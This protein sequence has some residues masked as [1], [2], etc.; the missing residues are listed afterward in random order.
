MAGYSIGIDLGTTY[1]CVGVFRNG[2]VEIIANSQGDRTTPSCVAFTDTDRLIG[3]AAMS[4]IAANPANT[5]YE[6]KRLIGRKWS[7]AKAQED[8]RNFGFECVAVA[9]DIQIKVEHCGEKK[10]FYPEQ[11]SA[12]VLEQLKNDAEAYL[13][14]K[15]TDAVITVPAYFNDAQRRKTEDAARIAGLNP[16]RIVNEPTAAALAYG[17]ETKTDGAGEK[18]VLVFDMGGGTHDVSLLEIDSGMVQTIATAGDTHLG[19]A[20]FDSRLVAHL[21]AEFKRRT[22]KDIGD[23]KRATA[24]LRAAAERAKRT[25]SS[26]THASIEIDALH[27][28]LDLYTSVSRARFEELCSDLFQKAMTP[29]DRVLLDARIDKHK[30]TDIILVG[31]STRVPKI[32]KLLQ[33]YFGGKELCKSVNPDECVAYGAAV[34]AAI[35]G[36]APS[37]KV[38]VTDMVLVDVCPL[39]LGIETLGGI[40]TALIKRNST[41]PTFA[42]QTFTT[43]EDGQPGVFIQVFEGE[44]ALTKDCNKLGEF[45]LEGIPPAQAGVPKIEVRF[46]LDANGTLEV[47]AKDTV[48]SKQSNITIRNREV[49]TPAEIEKMVREAELMATKDEIERERVGAYNRLQ[50][51]V[52]TTKQQLEDPKVGGKL[53]DSTQKE[54]RVVIDGALAWIDDNTAASKEE[55]EAQIDSIK[56]AATTAFSMLYKGHED[57]TDATTPDGGAAASD[58]HVDRATM[59]GGFQV[60]PEMFGAAA[61]MFGGGG[62]GGGGKGGE[63]FQVTPEMV[64]T[65]ARMFS[66]ASGGA[67]SSSSEPTIEEVD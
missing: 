22:K 37:Q 47:T 34:Q 49:R 30:I 8:I 67:A 66:G 57:D 35:L 50:S 52:Y 55:Y 42:T 26:C 36:S 20:D 43:H 2:H 56:R 60:T 25:L 61:K 15:V 48:S 7:D 62:G 3:S 24:R 41:I 45:Q 19:G 53:N 21:K 9:D 4:Q 38:G 46:D 40:M 28:G 29:V 64:Q 13:G 44:R 1:S 31:G 11:I 54:L 51:T 18:T 65:A 23:N 63:G 59:P 5:V 10:C 16:L 17:L 32:Q 14:S 6:A 39:S 58:D 33:E 12:M 27:E